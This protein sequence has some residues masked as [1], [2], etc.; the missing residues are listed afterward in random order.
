MDAHNFIIR[1]RQE[2]FSVREVN[3]QLG[4]SPASRLDDEQRQWISAHK[5]AILTALKSPG[6]EIDTGQG[7]HDLAAA[8]CYLPA[9]LAIA[10]ERVCREVHGDSDELVQGMLDDLR[11]ALPSDWDALTKHFE[12]Q[13]S[14]TPEL[15]GERI[16]VQTAGSQ[17][18][19]AGLTNNVTAFKVR[20]SVRFTLKD[21]GGGG[22]VL[23]EPGIPREALVAGLQ[24]RYGDQ[25]ATIDGEDQ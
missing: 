4:I 25:L 8:N 13:L 18:N 17:S 3:G 14:P 22:S 24:S 1:M 21:N 12:S 9:R 19:M 20:T 15:G 7:G 23:G 10:A 6:T 11:H 16:T 5:A 2:G